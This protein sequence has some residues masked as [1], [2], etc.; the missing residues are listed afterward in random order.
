MGTTLGYESILNL[1]LPSGVD[2]TLLAQWELATGETFMGFTQRLASALAAVNAEFQTDWGNLFYT[3]E[4]QE[5][6]YRN[7][8]TP[9]ASPVVTDLDVVDPTHETTIGHQ[10]ALEVKQEVIGG[11]ER[12]FLDAR[13]MQ[14]TSD[15]GGKIDNLRKRFE[16]DLLN[17]A[18]LTTEYSVGTSGYNVPWVHST[19]GNIDFVPVAYNGETFAST[20]DHFLG[21]ASGSYGFGDMLNQ[22]AETLQE[23]G[24][25]GP[26]Y[27]IVSRADIGSYRDLADF[28][29]PKDQMISIIDRAGETSG[30]NYYTTQ[31]LRKGVIGGFSSDYGEIELYATARVPTAYAFLTKSYG[32]LSPKNPFAVRLRPASRGGKGFGCYIAAVTGDSTISPIKLIRMEFEYGLGLGGDRT[33]GVA[34]YRSTGG[35]WTNPTIS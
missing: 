27:A 35:T 32:T 11:T 34:A 23:H 18:F 10:I 13:E 6:E 1:A 9:A 19:T 20:H 14:L 26:Y 5:F 29:R 25:D 8:G 30:P 3:T 2:A 22:M 21:V 7:G 15:I 28:I 33:N 16:T 4:T 17:R 24:H 31:A 12:W